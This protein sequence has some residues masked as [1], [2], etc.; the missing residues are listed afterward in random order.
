MNAF[1]LLQYTQGVLW[2]VLYLSMPPIIVATVVGLLVGLLQALTQIQDQTLPFA[3]KL[4]AVIFAI[5]IT[6]PILTAGLLEY[7]DRVFTDFPYVT[8]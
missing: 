3:V 4:I 1:D 6:A 5:I 2:I 8:R 7:T